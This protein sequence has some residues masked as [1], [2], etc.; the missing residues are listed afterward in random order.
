MR[1]CYTPF[2]KQEVYKLKITIELKE[3]DYGALVEMFLSLVE[4][5][6]AEK[7][8]TGA[9]ILAKIA[10]MLPA[11]ARNMVDLLPQET[12]VT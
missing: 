1:I 9:E 4:N 6:L 3:I 11:I 8:G 2:I 5:K 12:L 10:G 7:D